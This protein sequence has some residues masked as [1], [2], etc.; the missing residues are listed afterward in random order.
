[1]IL[2]GWLFSLNFQS[3]FNLNKIDGNLASNAIIII[4]IFM[5]IKSLL[6]IPEAIIRGNN[7]EYKTF[8]VDPLR[9][10]L[11]GALVYFLL[12]KGFGLMG[13]ISAIIISSIFDFVLRFIAQNYYLPNYK[14]S[15]PSTSK[16][17]EFTSS[18]SWYMGSSFFSQILNSF[19]II[20]IG[21]IFGMGQV[22]IY[23]LSKSILFRIAESIS[24][25]TGGITASIG[26]LIG[27]NRI[28]KLIK[29]RKLL[30]RINIIIGITIMSYFIIFNSSF[31]LLWVGASN[32]I[33]ESI[34]LIFSLTSFFVLLNLTDEIFINSLH[35][36]KEKTKVMLYTV[37]IAIFFGYLLS[38]YLGLIAIPLGLMIAKIYQWHSYQNIINQYFPINMKQ[39]LFKNYKIIILFVLTLYMKY[40]FNDLVIS[41]WFS[42]FIYS[43]LFIMTY[44]I[45]IFIFILKD[46]E[47]DYIKKIINR[48]FN[49][50]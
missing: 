25:I 45:I 13:I 11:Y 10:L 18:G 48:K 35:A 17:K 33:G 1:M 28:D 27:A 32:F 42:F 4:S 43:I 21:M 44:L 47:T 24:D 39:E 6:G 22:T 30:L 31:I 3:F 38:V 49:N 50:E 29:I 12:E 5:G 16:I 2:I 37:I 36:F 20:M 14:S 8:F 7:L 15:M 41:T 9:M 34:N 19:D 23:T 46:Y 26:E 40:I